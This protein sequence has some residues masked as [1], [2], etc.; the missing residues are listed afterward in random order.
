MISNIQIVILTWDYRL[1]EFQTTQKTIFNT[2]LPISTKR[3]FLQSLFKLPLDIRIRY[4]DLVFFKQTMQIKKKIKT[5][6]IGQIK[7]DG[8][9]EVETGSFLKSKFWSTLEGLGDRHWG[10]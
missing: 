5:A 9:R 6:T 3:Y 2:V 7:E 10:S 4:D 1:S 8:V